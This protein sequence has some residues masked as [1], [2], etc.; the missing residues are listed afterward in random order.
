[1]R[2]GSKISETL[3]QVGQFERDLSRGGG[4]PDGRIA[5]VGDG[6]IG[7]AFEGEPNS[8]IFAAVIGDRGVRSAFE[9][10]PGLVV[11][12]VVTH[13]VSLLLKLLRSTRSRPRFMALVMARRGSI[14]ACRDPSIVDDLAERPQL[15]AGGFFA[16]W[17]SG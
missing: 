2:P 14:A 13:G 1:M 6:G 8:V 12:A 17:P 5:V 9:D 4:C 7:R 16:G 10:A 11:F 3:P 15:T